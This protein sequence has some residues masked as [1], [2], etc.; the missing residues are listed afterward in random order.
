[1]LKFKDGDSNVINQKLCKYDKKEH[2]FRLLCKW[3]FD[4]T[5]KQYNKYKH[6]EKI[7]IYHRTGKKLNTLLLTKKVLHNK[8]ER[9]L[10]EHKH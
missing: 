3:T 2:N 6:S 5:Q 10:K 7:K 9:Y 8:L 1:M 4:N